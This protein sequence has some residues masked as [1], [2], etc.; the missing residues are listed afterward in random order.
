ME[1]KGFWNNLVEWAVMIVGFSLVLICIV[2]MIPWILVCKWMG[3]D[4]GY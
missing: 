4:S 1:C 3:K 2:L